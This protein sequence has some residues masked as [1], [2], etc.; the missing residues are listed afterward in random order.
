MVSRA[1]KQ[2]LGC[3]PLRPPPGPEPATRLGQTAPSWGVQLGGCSRRPSPSP[4]TQPGG[5][6][7]V[8]RKN[9]QRRLGW[10]VCTVSTT[11]SAS[12]ESP[13]PSWSVDPVPSHLLASCRPDLTP[14]HQPMLPHSHC[15]GGEGLREPLQA[16]PCSRPSHALGPDLCRPSASSRPFLYSLHTSPPFVLFPASTSRRPH[17]G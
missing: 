11:K 5:H 13:T 12:A 8:G 10:G 15:A 14:L 9:W 4:G 2:A 1:K 17:H 6:S 7:S 3:Q 16:N